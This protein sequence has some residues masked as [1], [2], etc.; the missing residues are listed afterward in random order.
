MIQPGLHN[1][2]IQQNAD[3]DQTFQLFDGH[4]D[5][6]NLTGSTVE[7]EIWTAGKHAK[8]ADFGVLILDAALGKFSL[9]LTDQVTATLPVSGYYDI[10][11]T[12]VYGFSYY[13][14]RGQATV[15]TGCTE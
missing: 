1:I 14:V 12:D 9:S 13:W 8:L 6:V 3:W 5:P 2:T 4:G 15:E 7:A 11:V 10:R